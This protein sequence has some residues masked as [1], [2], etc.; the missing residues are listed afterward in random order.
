MM[1]RPDDRVL[2]VG[3]G[4]S[5]LGVCRFLLGKNVQITLADRK[6]RKD[7]SQDILD[8]EKFGVQLL[9]AGRLSEGLKNDPE[10]Y[11]QIK[12]QKPWDYV[13]KSPGIDPSIPLIKEI[14]ELGIPVVGDIELLYSQT[15][16]PIIG[17]TGTNGK[18][19]TTALTGEILKEAGVN[20]LVGGNIGRSVLQE[21]EEFKGAIVLELSS[22]QL[23]T[24]IAFRPYIGVILNVTPDHLDRHGT[25]E[26]YLAAKAR[27]YQCQTQN[28]FL[29]LNYDD[30]MLRY[31]PTKPLSKVVYFS[32]KEVLPE[33]VYVE[34]GK[35]VIA[36]QIENKIEKA[37]VIN[38]K[39]IF[40]KGQHNVENALAATAAAWC[41]G[42]KPEQIGKTLST[43]AGVE[44]RLEVVKEKDGILYINDSK[45]TNPDS[46]IKALEAYDR[47]IILLAGGRN[48]GSNFYSLM[49][50]IKE[51]VKLLILLGEAKDDFVAACK[52]FDY[53]NYVPVDSFK[54]AV[55]TAIAAAIPGDVVMLSPAC[56]SWDMFRNFEERGDL[57]KALVKMV[58]K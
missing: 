31:L 51:K 40:I 3:G 47:P 24:C 34:D 12:T 20:T 14:L 41:Y 27:I 30:P 42:V 44:H 57:F 43:F 29:V 4:I 25:M 9:L 22:F 8:L 15:K 26:N 13:V 49:P 28:D 58:T 54:E 7:V 5:G 45:G 48:K 50:L 55:D 32:R 6:E 11:Q 10:Y 35:I 1:F 19:T 33:G 52:C 17:I 38:T 53:G 23:E 18:T 46:T 2:V 16:E 56:A 21:A 37:E 39:D 36:A